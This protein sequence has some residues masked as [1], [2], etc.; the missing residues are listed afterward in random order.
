LPNYRLYRLDGAGRIVSAEW[1]DAADDEAARQNARD[2][3]P[4][5]SCEIWQRGRLVARVQSPGD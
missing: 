2:R 1:L 4:P 5:V 3:E